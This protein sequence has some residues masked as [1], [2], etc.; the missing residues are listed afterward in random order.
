MK[1]KLWQF[2]SRSGSKKD[3]INTPLLSYLATYICTYTIACLHCTVMLIFL[4]VL[5]TL[6]L[7][8][9]LYIPMSTLIAPI[10]ISSTLTLVTLPTPVDDIFTGLP[11]TSLLLFRLLP[12]LFCH[13]TFGT[14]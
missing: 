9:H 4:V 7:A 6:L 8:E 14:G 13:T 12:S 3:S 5:P 2:L 11:V 10:T 1:A